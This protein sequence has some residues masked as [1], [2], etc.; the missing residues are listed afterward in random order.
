[1]E[2]AVGC[3]LRTILARETRPTKDTFRMEID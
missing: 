2:V 1:M 3:V